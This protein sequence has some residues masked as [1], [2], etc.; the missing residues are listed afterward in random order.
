MVL[1]SPKHSDGALH[2]CTVH[3]SHNISCMRKLAW[4][5]IHL[6]SMNGRATAP[7]LSSTSD[8]DGSCASGG[9]IT[10]ASIGRLRCSCIPFL[11]NKN[12]SSS[13]SSVCPPAIRISGE[14]DAT[15]R[16]YRHRHVWDRSDAHNKTSTRSNSMPRF[17]CTKVF[18]YAQL[19][20][21]YF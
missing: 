14:D 21:A 2:R 1:P 4:H 5:L 10:L 6:R 3:M 15:Q 17:V 19:H 16:V 9:K 13:W 11:A 20:A 12:T 7:W 18:M 8:L